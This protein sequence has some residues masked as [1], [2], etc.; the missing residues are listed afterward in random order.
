MVLL[1]IVLYDVKH[2][3]IPW[4]ASGLLAVLAFLHLFVSFDPLQLV[5]PDMWAI[6]SGP[7]LA[8]PLF[9]LSLVSMGRWMGW[10]DSPL[11]LSLGWLLGLTLGVAGLMLA[12][13]IG[14]IVGI[15]LVLLSRVGF[16]GY[17]IKSELPFAP[18]L[19][20]GAAIALF[21]HVTLFS[22]LYL[23]S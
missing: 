19:V 16:F 11:E 3:I 5:V 18:F 17:T 22:S 1:F 20:L 13:W 2:T 15:A 14:A 21:C 6:L 10:G 7:I 23:F 8:L 4:S 12:F 9:L